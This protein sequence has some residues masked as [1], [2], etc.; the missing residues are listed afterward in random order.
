MI[1]QRHSM[2]PQHSDNKKVPAGGYVALLSVLVVG[3]IGLSIA[4]TLLV[5]GVG[6]ARTSFSE[7]QANQARGLADACAED[8]LQEIRDSTTFTGSGGFSLGQ[9]TCSY[10]VT[11]TGGQARNIEASGT[12]D[13]VTR[14][15][16]I[17][18][19]QINPTINITS[20]QEVADF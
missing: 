16:E 15:V 3:A 12:V 11:N 19:D 17:D 1:I 20:W 5:L 6:S 10:T 13:N 4:V 18:I 7:E 2:E 9:G 8:A 14:K